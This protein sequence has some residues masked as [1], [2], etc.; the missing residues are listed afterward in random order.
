MIPVKPAP[1][2]RTAMQSEQM[3]EINCD[4]SRMGENIYSRARDQ[5]VDRNAEVLRNGSLNIFDLKIDGPR[6]RG[7]TEDKLCEPHRPIKRRRVY[8][9]QNR[10]RLHISRIETIET[11]FSRLTHFAKVAT[12]PLA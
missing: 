6:R 2:F 5:I 8:R 9:I 12:P 1:Y 7:L 10:L 11:G 3:A 4:L